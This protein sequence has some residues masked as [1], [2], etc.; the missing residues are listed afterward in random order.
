MGNAS[1]AAKPGVRTT[2]LWGKVIL[3][4]VLVLNA[5]FDLG[6]QISDD[7]AIGIAGIMESAYSISRAMSKRVGS[8]AETERLLQALMEAIEKTPHKPNQP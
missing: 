2:E 6:I 5:L 8:T 1:I 7:L 4:A 3:Q